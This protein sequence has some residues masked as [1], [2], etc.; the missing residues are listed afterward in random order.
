[1]KLSNTS[2]FC[3]DVSCD[4]YRK[5]DTIFSELL[6]RNVNNGKNIYSFRHFIS[7]G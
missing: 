3:L 4:Y 2:S 7:C 6:E 5:N 1:M